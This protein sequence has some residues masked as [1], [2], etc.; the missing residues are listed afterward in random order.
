M[1]Y[2]TSKF[3]LENLTNTL[4]HTDTSTTKTML[5]VLIIVL[6]GWW[7]VT[8]L[9]LIPDA[10]RASLDLTKSENLSAMN[11]PDQTSQAMDQFADGTTVESFESLNPNEVI[12]RFPSD[13]KFASFLLS[14][15]DSNVTLFASLERLRAVRIGYEDREALEQLLI[16]ENITIYDSISR[17][18]QRGRER[19]SDQ[20]GLVGFGDSL[21]TWS[22]VQV[23]HSS[24]GRGVKVAVLDSGIVPHEN[25]PSYVRSVE[26]HP[27]PEDL[28]QINGHGTAVASLIV[29]MRDMAPGIAPSAELISV[30]VSDDNGLAD[31]FAIAEGILAAVDEGADLINISMG[32]EEDNPLIREAVLYAQGKQK[33]I[34]ASSGNSHGAEANYPA[35]YPGVI[36]VGSVDALGEHLDF[37][38]HGKSLSL[39]APGCAVNAAWP[40]NQYIRMSGTSVSAPIVTAAI[41]ATMSNGNGRRLTAI[42]AAEMVIK[43]A[44][45]AGIPGPDTQYGFGIVN[46]RRVMTRDQNGIMDVAITDQRIIHSATGHTIQV[47]IQN[48]GTEILA[49]TLVKVSA[50]GRNWDFNAAILAPCSIQS[51][52]VPISLDR[53]SVNVRSAIYSAYSNRDITPENNRRSET[54]QQ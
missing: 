5:F 53:N 33:V 38:N 26:I 31:S 49:N 39:T 16:S 34:I 20:E 54:F 11:R 22:G 29:G 47:A 1:H 8:K 40:G 4:M 32:T 24:W 10:K 13:A 37:A 18:P 25:L 44:D 17:F 51:F 36:S 9:G 14:L 48:R 46:L 23:D 27:F 41:A 2:A 50:L 12:L 42:E 52:S 35:A 7:L 3:I 30:R 6:F 19:S 21:L 43:Y 45:E 28:G 15:S